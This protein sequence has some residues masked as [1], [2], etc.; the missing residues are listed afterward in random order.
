[1][2]AYVSH[3]ARSMQRLDGLPKGIQSSHQ[4][5]CV[6]YAGRRNLQEIRIGFDARGKQATRRGGVHTE[7]GDQQ[8]SNESRN[9]I[10][11]DLIL[12]SSP[13]WDYRTGGYK[14]GT[15]DPRFGG[16]NGCGSFQWKRRSLGRKFYPLRPIAPFEHL[17]YDRPM[18]RGL[19]PFLFS[20]L[21]CV[22]AGAADVKVVQGPTGWKLL[23]DGKPYVVRGVCYSADK[24]GED[25]N[26][27]TLQDWMVEDDDRDGKIDA[28]Y[29]SWVDKNRNDRQDADEPTVGDFKLLQ[30]MG[31]NTIR[32]YHHPSGDKRLQALFPSGTEGD[33]I[34]NHAPNKTLLRDLFANYGIRVGMGDDL[35]SYTVGSG[36][37]WQ[38]GTDYLNA[39]QKENMRKSVE[40]MVQEFKNEPYI[41]FWVLGNENNYRFTHTNA[42]SHPQEYAQF[43]NDVVRMIH[44]LDPHH[45]VVLANGE[46][47]QIR[48]YAKY[49]PD[50]DSFGINTYRRPGFGFLWR[51]VAS[52]YKKPVILTEFGVGVP[53]IVNGVYDEDFQAAEHRQAWCDIENHTAGKSAPGNALGGF[54]FAW[55]D[56]WWQDAQPYSLFMTPGKWN[57]EAV[58]LAS[59]GN[60]SHSPFERQLRKSY[61]MFQGLWG[62]R[63]DTCVGAPKLAGE[64]SLPTR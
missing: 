43:V 47:Q 29:Q 2:G 60:G 14:F 42:A 51:D 34:Y 18:R 12:E 5:L 22:S 19:L 39:E 30:E 25:P 6:K 48:V 31:V 55:L 26:R 13:L 21:L 23:V 50:V 61:F 16:C 20:C 64:T 32:I 40:S 49:A 36:A 52:D 44:R 10:L 15:E 57:H 11:H 35:G 27:S 1:M 28:P 33:L 41:L 7:R 37:P 38:A 54:V 56:N 4:G 58:G 59:Q 17:E 45:P 9:T 53:R 46:T 8:Q 63:S 24:V 3:D 62:T